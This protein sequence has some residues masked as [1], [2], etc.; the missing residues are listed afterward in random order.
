MGSAQQRSNSIIKAKSSL[1]KIDKMATALGSGTQRQ[2]YQPFPKISVVRHGITKIGTLTADEQ[3]ARIFCVY[4]SLNDPMI[5]KSLSNDNRYA[6]PRSENDD[7]ENVAPVPIG[8]MGIKDA[9][10]WFHLFEDTVLYHSW[11]YA[12]ELDLD[13]LLP[14]FDDDSDSS[15]DNHNHTNSNKQFHRNRSDKIY[16]GNDSDSMHFIRKYLAD[17][18]SV[19]NRSDGNEHRLV[20]FHQQLHNPRQVLKD[21][22]LLNV[23]GGRCESIAIQSSKNPAAISQKRAVKLNWQIANNLFDDTSVKD[24]SILQES[25]Q[26]FASENLTNNDSSNDSDSSPGGSHFSIYINDPDTATNE[27]GPVSILMK[28]TGRSSRSQ[29]NQKVTEAL[30][31]RLFFNTSVGGCLKHNSVIKGFTE[32]KLEGH[33]YRSHPSYWGERPW[34]DWA[35]VQWDHDSDPYPAQI[36]MFLDLSEATFMNEDELDHFRNSPLGRRL[37]ERSTHPQTQRQNNYEYLTRTMWMVVR[38]S[39][40]HAEQGIRLR[41]EYRVSSRIFKRYYMEDEYRIIPVDSI[42]GPAFCLHVNGTVD[43][44]NDVSGNDQ[45][46]SLTDKNQWKLLFLNNGL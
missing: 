22:V 34:Y 9:K 23:D 39:L 8:S 4:L 14:E 31:K 19:L 7:E 20:K 46:I 28:W 12:D 11:L 5:F 13:H 25:L 2:S 27:T 21:G 3:F 16:D 24:A 40:S 17:L 29:M 18:K 33:T 10:K 35:M 44:S 26:E 1:K 41:D 36:C 30:V 42:E 38:S 32:L 45:I 15:I 43:C 6:R 37:M